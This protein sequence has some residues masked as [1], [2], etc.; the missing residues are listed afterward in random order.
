MCCVTSEK[1][2]ELFLPVHSLCSSHFSLYGMWYGSVVLYWEG[3]GDGTV[4]QEVGVNVDLLEGKGRV[5]AMTWAGLGWARLWMPIP[6]RGKLPH[7]LCL[8]DWIGYV[9]H[10]HL[11]PHLLDCVVHLGH[12]L[13]LHLSLGWPSM[14]S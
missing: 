13:F 9:H 5:T 1:F 12:L 2:C 8:A 6:G 11:V 10:V 4:F 14:G 7:P 3:G